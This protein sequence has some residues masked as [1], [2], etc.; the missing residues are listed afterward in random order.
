[1]MCKGKQTSRTCVGKLRTKCA[2][3]YCKRSL[4]TSDEGNG[5][6]DGTLEGSILSSYGDE[7]MRRTFIF[8]S[9]YLIAESFCKSL[10]LVAQDI[11]YG[12]YQQRLRQALSF[13]VAAQ[14]N[15]DGSRARVGVESVCTVEGFHDFSIQAIA[16][17]IQ[18]PRLAT[19]V[20]G[21]RHRIEQ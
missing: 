21:F 7:E 17:A 8:Y 4:P 15:A 3:P 16:L 9:L 20:K 11:P 18:L 14:A 13:V 1:M 19:I 12:S 2:Q 5:I 10:A 6:L